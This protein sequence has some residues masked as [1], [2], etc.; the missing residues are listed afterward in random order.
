MNIKVID[1]DFKKIVDVSPKH[2]YHGFW[3]G[4][5]G[6]LHAE[7]HNILVKQPKFGH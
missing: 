7:G 1:K 3:K 6:I 4:A 5:S 2:L